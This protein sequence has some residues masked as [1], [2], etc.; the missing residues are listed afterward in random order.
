MA[1]TI[2]Q[3][4]ADMY[5][6]YFTD[7]VEFRQSELR[8][9]SFNY[10]GKGDKVS[11]IQ[12]I[13]ADGSGQVVEFDSKGKPARAYNM[14]K[15]GRRT[16]IVCEQTDSIDD[17]RINKELSKMRASKTKEVAKETTTSRK[18]VAK[19]VKLNPTLVAKKA[20]EKV[21]RRA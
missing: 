9:V 6:K 10:D 20:Q 1:K 13:S 16:P 21:A 15:N 11:S 12:Y 7:K 14:A 18:P 3:I 19:K 8:T 17:A 2:E 5:Q 4:L